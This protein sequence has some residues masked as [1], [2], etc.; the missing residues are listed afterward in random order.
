MLGNIMNQR[1]PSETNAVCPKIL[2]ENGE[3]MQTNKLIG[4]MHTN[5]L[6][7]S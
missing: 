7:K 6:L 3:K 5:G 4:P 2:D 1:E